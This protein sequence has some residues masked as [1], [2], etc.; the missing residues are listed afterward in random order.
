[1]KYDKRQYII[2]GMIARK[3]INIHENSNYF[4]MNIGFM[5]T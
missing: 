4:L 2:C 5:D 1:M 3:T